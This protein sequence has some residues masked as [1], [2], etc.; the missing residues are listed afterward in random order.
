MMKPKELV[1]KFEESSL[2]EQVLIGLAGAVTVVFALQFL[3]IDSL[4]NE[5]EKVERRVVSLS[6]TQMS[7]QKKLT[8]EPKEKIEL[9][10]K[11]KE[12]L[13]QRQRVAELDRQ[14]SDLS[15]LLV[16]PDVMPSLLQSLVATSDMKMVAFENMVPQPLLA[17]EKS[18][19][20]N[21]DSNSNSTSQVGKPL[22]LFRHGMS[23]Q[24]RGSFSSSLKYLK[25]VE[26]QPWGFVWNSLDYEVDSYPSGN[27]TIKIET[28]ST[29][30]HWLG[31]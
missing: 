23:I 11:K 4:I 7:L 6:N 14:L 24:L 18:S 10:Q 30:Q 12:F 27:L 2:R 9:R 3:I 26:S 29:D 17:P 21:S 13:V 8:Y 5:T 16:A 19:S 22:Q 28:L 20:L 1:Q 31:V 15:S 25:S